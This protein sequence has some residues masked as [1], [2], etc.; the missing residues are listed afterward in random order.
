VRAGSLQPQ[1]DAMFQGCLADSSRWAGS[2]EVLWFG[3]ERL[4]GAS[5]SHT[6]S[7]A[8]RLANSGLS[9]TTP[10]SL[11]VKSAGCNASDLRKLN[12]AR[13]TFGR[14]GSVMSNTKAAASSRPE[15]MMLSIGSSSP[16]DNLGLPLPLQF[17]IGEAAA[18][19]C[20]LG[21][22]LAC[23]FYPHFTSAGKM[24]PRLDDWWQDMGKLSS[25]WDGPL[26]PP[27][28]AELQL[29]LGFPKLS[30]GLL[31]STKASLNYI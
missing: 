8:T 20:Q 16:R 15:C 25:C 31:M 3:V 23:F 5:R 12:T 4:W 10:S 11:I 9:L 26:G 24:P 28:R 2:R 22:A 21:K 17:H 30:T 18:G 29:N 7:F 13:S 6:A 1:P 27:S 19:N 14:S